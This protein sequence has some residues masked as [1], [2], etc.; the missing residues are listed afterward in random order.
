MN[1]VC[2]WLSVNYG[3]GMLFRVSLQAQEK[4][5]D[6]MYQIKIVFYGEPGG[7]PRDSV[8]LKC[9]FCSGI[10]DS[11]DVLNALF[12][13]SQLFLQEQAEHVVEMLLKDGGNL[14]NLMAT[15]MEM[16]D[17]EV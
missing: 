15:G 1:E 13:C 2:F 6:V 16:L 5:V 17:F 7:P 10:L 8:L 11:N 3:S 12:S 9:T 4:L 14:L